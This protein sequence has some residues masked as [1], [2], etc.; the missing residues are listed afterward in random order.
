MLEILC[1][2]L[3]DLVLFVLHLASRKKKKTNEATVVYGVWYVDF[4]YHISLFARVLFRL[5]AHGHA[6]VWHI[7][8][9]RLKEKKNIPWSRNIKSK[10][11]SAG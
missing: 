10:H 1:S 9:E 6:A 8:I 3:V 5:F 11:K 2:I 7:E 4:Y